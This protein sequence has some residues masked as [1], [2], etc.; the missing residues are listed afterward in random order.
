MSASRAIL[1]LNAGSSSVKFSVFD[2]GAKALEARLRGRVESLHA[3]PRLVARDREARLLAEENLAGGERFG[4]R[5]S[6]A[7]LFDWLTNHGVDVASVR[8]V[9]HRVVHGGTEFTSPVVVDRKVIDALEKLVPLAPLHQPHNLAAIEA[10]ANR[11]PNLPQVACF[12][13]SFHRTQPAIAQLYALPRKM[14]DRGIRRYGFHGLSYEYIAGKLSEFDARAAD[15]RTVVAHLGNGASMC[16]LQAGRSVATSMGFTAVEGL[17]MGT[18]SGSLDP[19]V[20]LYLL[21]HEG[22]DAEAIQDLLYHRSGL[23]GVSE[24]SSDMRA[25]LASDDP[26]AREAVDLF[27]YRIV[28]ELGSLA[29]ALGGLDAIVFTGGIGENAAPIRHRVLEGAVWLGVK[30]DPAANER[31][32]PRISTDASEIA[33]LVIPTDEEQMIARHVLRLLGLGNEKGGD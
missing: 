8:A 30:I 18:R 26:R 27:V 29:S 25:L 28:R 7:Y 22:Y 31:H 19:G 15:G 20:L 1:V 23:L 6:I 3:S 24:I 14:T 13:T 17:P 32:G 4:H 9:G 5:E 21:S 12:D 33:A 11:L 10:L 16:A 2:V